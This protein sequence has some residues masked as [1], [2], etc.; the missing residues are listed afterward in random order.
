MAT[1]EGAALAATEETVP[2]FSLV[3]VFWVGTP[4]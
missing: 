4:W 1:T 2:L 3:L